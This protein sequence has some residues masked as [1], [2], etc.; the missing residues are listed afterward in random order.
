MGEA[1]SPFAATDDSGQIRATWDQTES[2][3]LELGFAVKSVLEAPE[4]GMVV[5][6]LLTSVSSEIRLADLRNRLRRD[7]HDA[8]AGRE[9]LPSSGERR[10][11]RE[12]RLTQLRTRVIDAQ[13]A[14][15]ALRSKRAEPT[16]FSEG[17]S[18]QVLVEAM[19]GL[20]TRVHVD[21]T[22]MAS[23]AVP[24]LG[25]VLTSCINAVAEATGADLNTPPETN[26][27]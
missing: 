13:E 15:T 27:G 6:G 20:Y 19:N 22:F 3:N 24:A 7:A 23:T 17:R 11:A 5:L 4:F 2:W 16:V 18:D 9:Y 21:P 14:V 10:H 26:H 1:T 8:A 12:E 25:Q